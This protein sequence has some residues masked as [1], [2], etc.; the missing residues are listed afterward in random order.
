MIDWP[1]ITPEQMRGKLWRMENL[2]YIQDKAG[3]RVLFKLWPEQRELIGGLHRKNLILKARQRGMTTFIQIFMLDEAIFTDDTS[4]GV[5]AHNADDASHFF[6]SKIKFAYDIL[7]ESMPPDMQPRFRASKSNKKEL[8]FPNGSRIVV[9]VSLRSGTY[10]ILHISEYGKLCAQ[11]P[12]KAEEV[13]SGALNTVPPDGIVFIEST[14]EGRRGHFAS[15]CREGMNRTVDAP[16][17]IL[18]Y[19]FWFFPWWRSPEYAIDERVTISDA[20]RDYFADL[21]AEHGIQLAKKQKWWYVRKADEQGEKMKQEY[22]STPEE[23]F[24]KL[25]MGAIFANQL[26]R[27]RA[28]RRIVDLPL[29]RGEPVNGFWDLGRNDIN[30]IW[31]H[32][33]V[34]P[35]EHFIDYYESRLVDIT[36]YVEKLNE[37]AK[38][39][40]YQWGTMYLPHDGAQKHITA[41]AGSAADILRRYGYKVRVLD[42]PIHKITTIEAARKR[43]PSCRF[44]RERCDLGIKHLEDYQ[45]TW[46]PVGE[47]YRKT[48]KHNAAS[49]AADAIQTFGWHYA[50]GQHGQWSAQS[51]DMT[52][53][54]SMGYRRGRPNRSE[55][56]ARHIL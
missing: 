33:R 3:N 36:H 41:I 22:P 5:C 26:Q 13:R 43:F 55:T 7:Y 51:R 4:C 19:K 17:T 56:D 37:L 23:A 34:G 15:L 44:D 50:Q 42:R 46:D 54:A 18:D 49:N 35:W 11:T 27:M 2:Y 16:L 20:M 30:A 14:A 40:G 28:E 47:T 38:D 32:Q 48:P 8:V 29:E 21:E 31:F 45:W 12:D 6:Y 9:G 25:L 1:N 39:R 53:A 52:G 24:E 10:Q